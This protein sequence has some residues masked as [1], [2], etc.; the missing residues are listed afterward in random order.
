MQ[1]VAGKGRTAGSGTLLAAPAGYVLMGTYTNAQL[2]GCRRTQSNPPSPT[3]HYLVYEGQEHL[4]EDSKS[5]REDCTCSKT[6]LPRLA[7][8]PSAQYTG[9]NISQVA[10]KLAERLN[11]SELT[12][13]EWGAFNPMV[14]MSEI[15]AVSVT[16]SFKFHVNNILI[17]AK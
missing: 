3:D 11:N 15:G 9:K 17:V 13:H 6:S 12:R 1:V 10:L 5:G 7:I 16:G 2:D 14:I 8:L 4:P